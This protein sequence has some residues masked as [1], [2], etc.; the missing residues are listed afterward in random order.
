M[1]KIYNFSAGPSVLPE[2]AMKQA[3][4]EFLNYRNTG[5]SVLEMSHRSSVFGK[6]IESAE[7][8]L[9]KLLSITDHFQV[10]FL[11]GGAS[12]QFAMVP[13]NL[14]HDKTGQADFID[15]GSWSGKAIQEAGRYGEVRVVAT[16]EDENFSYIPELDRGKCNPSADFFHITMNNTI[17]GTRFTSIP[18]TG[19]VPLVADMSSFI[20]SEAIDISKFGLVYAGAQKNIAPAGLTIVILRKDLLGRHMA[21]TPV[22]LQYKTHADNKSLYNT[23]PCFGIYFADLVFQWIEEMGGIHALETINRE[24][25]GLLYDC[26]DNSRLFRGTSRKEHRSLM[27]VTFLLPNEDLTKQFIAEAETNGLIALKG[28]RSMGG[29]RASLYNAMPVEGVKKL[30]SFMEKFDKKN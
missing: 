14:F 8:R 1:E 12:L 25:A 11:Q 4:K 18:T 15:T 16:S 6:I 23:P 22:M 2:A 21:V 7:Q 3:Q 24:K 10:L 26:I 5:I 9:R 13:L 28:H 20:L 19:S 17:F 30:I 27:N 29:L